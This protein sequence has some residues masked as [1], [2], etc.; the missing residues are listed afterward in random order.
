HTPYDVRFGSD[1]AARMTPSQRDSLRAAARAELRAWVDSAAAGLG[2][3]VNLPDSI[4]VPVD[5]AALDSIAR[6]TGTGGAGADT[7]RR[8]PSRA[9]TLRRDSLAPDS[10]RRPRGAPPPAGAQDHARARQHVS[11]D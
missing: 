2:I 6:Q 3:G 10:V 1:S 8:D 7:S 11:S 9:D 4:P 5:S